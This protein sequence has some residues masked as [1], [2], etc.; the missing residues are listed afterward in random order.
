MKK[1]QPIGIF[2]SG[3]GGITV[4][5]H[6][7]DLLPDESLAYVADSLY[8][9][10]GLKSNH[11]ILDRSKA[12]I[13]YLIKEKSVKLIVVAC[14]TATAAAIKELRQLYEI[15]IVGM[16]ELVFWQQ[17]ERWRVQN[18]LHCLKLIQE[19]LNFTHSLALV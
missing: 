13:D 8:A 6:I 7:H 10:Y 3:V 19:I 16:E 5:S 2:D 15:P 18:F 17:M 12:V 14:N 9:P 4:M 1:T 11:E